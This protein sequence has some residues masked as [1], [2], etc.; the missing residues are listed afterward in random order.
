MCMTIQHV[1]DECAVVREPR[2]RAWLRAGLAAAC[3]LWSIP[4]AA[5]ITWTGATNTTWST[6]T[7]WSTGTTPSASETAVFGTT[8]LATRQPTIAATGTVGGMVLDAA[9]TFTL[10]N[11]NGDFTVAGNVTGTAGF[12][13]T[14][15]ATSNFGVLLFTSTAN[16]FSGGAATRGSGIL[17]YNAGGSVNTSLG[18]GTISIDG[19]TFSLMGTAIATS[20]STGMPTGNGGT[21]RNLTNTILATSAG[22]TL[23]MNQGS[24]STG[25]GLAY[26]AVILGGSLQ[27]TS[28]GGGNAGGYT[29]AGTFTLLQDA[30]RT[31]RFTNA[32]GHNGSDWIAGRITDGAGSAANPLRLAVTGRQLQISN[33]GNNY[34]GGTIVEAGS[35]VYYLEITA[36]GVLGTGN[37]TVESGGRIRLSNPTAAGTAGNLAGTATVGVAAGGVVGVNGNADISGRVTA[38]SAGIYGIEGSRSYALDMTT[39]GSGSMFLGTMSGGSY[40]ASTLGVGVGNI[41][42]LGGGGSVAPVSG[43]R[44]VLTLTQANVLT[45]NAALVVGPGL[46]VANS[47]G[48]V[49]AIAASQNFSGGVTVSADG[50]LST[51]TGSG[52][53]PFGDT[54]RSIDVYGSIGASG[55]GGV[56]NMAY[57]STIR[58]KPGSTL[59]FANDGFNNTAG[60]NNND[61]WG[62]STAVPKLDGATLSLTSQR[63]GS[64]TSETVG[65]VTFK[66]NAR[67][68]VDGASTSPPLTTL[69][70]ASLAREGTGVLTI[71][72]QGTLGSG[73]GGAGNSQLIVSAAPT[74][75][76]G[77]VAPW[78]IRSD[79]NFLT[80]GGTFT[81]YGNATYST[82]SLNAATTTDVVNTGSVTLS[83]NPSVYALRYTDTVNVSGANT[84][85]T[86]GSGGVI[87]AGNNKTNNA[88]MSS[89]TQELIFWATGGTQTFA[90]SAALQT[91]GGFIKAG[92]SQVSLT[93]T[94]TGANYAITGGIT[95]QQ[96]TILSGSR[97][98]LALANNPLTVNHEGRLDLNNV[99]AS[100]L[101]L[102]GAGTGG[103][104]TNSGANVR[105]FTVT[106]GSGTTDTYEGR[107]SGA[108]DLVK[109]G[110][111]TLVL[112]G[113]STFSG[114]TGISAGT[115]QVGNGGTTGSIS[116]SSAVSVS[117]GAVL[118]FNRADAVVYGGTVS[119]AGGFTKAGAGMLTLTAAQ[120][121]TGDTVV[122]AGTLK[123]G[124]D[125]SLA[126][127]GRIVVGD[128]ASS[129]AVLDIADRTSLTVGAGQTLMGK[130]TVMLAASTNLTVA[131]LYAP[132]NSPGL[133][134]YD[135][136]GTV[137]LTGTTLLE[138]SGTAAGSG[139]DSTAVL[140]G[141]DLVLGGSLQLNFSRTFADGTIFNVFTASGSGSSLSG[142]FSSITM[143]GTSYTDLTFTN[144][145]GAW[146]TNTG[147]TNQSM[148][149]DGATGTLAILVVPEPSACALAAVGG[150][151]GV[152]AIARRRRWLR[153]DS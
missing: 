12:G 35:G 67:V 134:T 42:R 131:G 112:A 79:G 21:D 15:A 116:G 137:A 64:A 66:G 32:T 28:Q 128:A 95:I 3:A 41:Y 145:G 74:T 151:L 105:T 53:T 47:S 126:G 45:G 76:N 98:A 39:L 40:G 56:F 82:T 123:L 103:N 59:A 70:I 132:G 101:G 144:S 121:Y 31:L 11:F 96:G 135:G 77:I 124:A 108:I 23:N 73:A 153:R 133:F 106:V 147:T 94:G 84:T 2:H 38:T 152:T 110:A 81:G 87:A 130:G 5:Q 146:T 13:V 61:R 71:T 118:A 33:T 51:T 120:A 18:S 122:A 58:L 50:V 127:S 114:T 75:T 72:G 117:S 37:L 139:Y 148:S 109:S 102:R 43:A 91:S 6:A 140:G 1:T 129:N 26:N 65:A 143:V 60:L 107:V 16:T 150:L 85:I 46:N 4:V 88:V 104:V 68:T 54:S 57:A 22:G 99:A 19:G 44:Q 100:V 10:T 20:T 27:T 97:F 63:G 36:N 49:V 8:G 29:I 119:G 149:F 111:G 69:T 89:G 141:T 80:Y 34:A 78:A 92:A 7:N 25:F 86:I 93:N 48:G 142:N 62:D 30:T 115:L 83:T 17:R 136:G 55:T 24:G 125:G 90:N 14:S 138:F 9:P 52:N 113:A